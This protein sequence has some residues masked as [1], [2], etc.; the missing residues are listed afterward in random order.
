MTDLLTV[1]NAVALLTLTALEVVLGIDNIV[2][3][4][5]VTSKLDPALQAR[6]RRLGLA[7]A[8]IMR[9]ALL[10]VIGSIMRLTEP[11][12]SLRD[13]AVSGKDLIL[14]AGGLFLIAK[15]TYEIHDK[16]EGL[17]PVGKAQRP[18]PSF[19]AAIAQIVMLDLI[20]SLDS[21]ITAVGMARSI[22]IMI[23]AVIVAV[24]VM[25]LFAGRIS[26]FVEHHP[27]LKVL[28]LA[29]LLLIGVMLVAE[30]CHQNIEKGYIY[31]ALGFSLLVELLNIKI[32]KG[33]GAAWPSSV[34][35]PSG[36]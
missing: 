7:L 3:L 25:L 10:L 27:T 28:A 36:S 9:I 21:V 15:S 35:S 2:F 16:M 29:F 6:A 20:F 24:G 19:R 22:L 17:H 30:G 12:F 26:R 18:R 32:H 4:T 14:L 5:I 34:E 31:F 1:E 33:R 13:H 23:V 11:W 8:M